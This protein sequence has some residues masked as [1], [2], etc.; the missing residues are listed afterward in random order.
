LLELPERLSH[1]EFRLK[2]LHQEEVKV[3]INRKVEED[4]DLKVAA[5]VRNLDLDQM[6]VAS[7]HVNF[8]GVK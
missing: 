3:L 4:Q 2:K 1:L 5:D 6:S 7:D 8:L